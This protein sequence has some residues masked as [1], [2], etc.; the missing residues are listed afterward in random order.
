MLLRDLGK[1]VKGGSKSARL[2]AAWRE[3]A[4]SPARPGGGI[5]GLR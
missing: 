4:R 3:G 5:I 1:R 2:E